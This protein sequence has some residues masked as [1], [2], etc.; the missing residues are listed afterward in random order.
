MQGIKWNKKEGF[1]IIR[2]CSIMEKSNQMEKFLTEY[3]EREFVRS[4][5]NCLLGEYQWI[6]LGKLKKIKM[7]EKKVKNVLF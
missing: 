1:D 5:K 4:K 6:K 3:F 7:N 2:K